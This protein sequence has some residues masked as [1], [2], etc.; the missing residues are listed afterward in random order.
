MLYLDVG[1]TCGGVAHSFCTAV[2]WFP[3]PK[4]CRQDCPMSSSQSFYSRCLCSVVHSHT[5]GFSGNVPL[6]H[7]STQCPGTSLHVI[8]FTR[9]STAIVLQVRRPGYEA[10]AALHISY[11]LTNYTHQVLHYALDTCLAPL[12]SLATP[13]SDT[14]H[15]KCRTTQ[16]LDASPAS[17]TH[18]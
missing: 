2:K 7:T 17:H 18:L 10:S 6:L 11:Y 12:V 14:H 16:N 13:T 3:K 9:P 5:C 8:S 4:K 1:W 15:S